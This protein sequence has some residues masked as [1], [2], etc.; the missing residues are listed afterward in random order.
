MLATSGSGTDYL[1]VDI[2]NLTCVE[3]DCTAQVLARGLCSRH[4]NR[5]RNSGELELMVR[6][7][8]SLVDVEAATAECSI[9]GPTRIRVRRDGKSHE[10]W[11]VRARNW[12]QPSRASK[13][14]SYF[15]SKY[16]IGTVEI[17]EMSARQNGQCAICGKIPDTLVVDHDHSTGLV[18][19]LLCGHCNVALGFLMD[20]ANS[21]RSAAD[22]L[23][24]HSA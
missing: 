4:Y 21:A 17:A 10:C 6:H 18:R 20:N 24:K 23:L 16:G 5:L 3:P 11:T 8:L 7:K 9:C 2:Y 1:G 15:K 14:E 22:Y 12:G 19:E 13:R